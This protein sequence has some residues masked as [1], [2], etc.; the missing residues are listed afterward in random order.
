MPTTVVNKQNF[1]DVMGQLEDVLYLDEHIVQ[2]S[3]IGDGV[4]ELLGGIGGEHADEE[5]DE[6]STVEL[7]NGGNH[8]LGLM[9]LA[10]DE[11]YWKLEMGCEELLDAK[12]FS[13]AKALELD[14]V[15]HGYFLNEEAAPAIVQ[16]LFQ[17]SAA[18]ALSDAEVAELSAIRKGAELSVKA[19]K[20]YACLPEA[21]R[22]VSTAVLSWGG[23]EQEAA[24][25]SAPSKE[26]A[27]QRA[28]LIALTAKHAGISLDEAYAVRSSASDWHVVLASN[29]EGNDNTKAG[30]SKDGS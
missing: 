13:L 20:K 22:F 16:E 5:R 14:A 15:L 19:A 12:G 26:L 9:Y 24:K 25:V 21:H 2:A 18:S 8:V 29:A 4:W 28:K 27:N 11:G 3:Q 6:R 23:E 17:R 7:I 30:F 10:D 1:A